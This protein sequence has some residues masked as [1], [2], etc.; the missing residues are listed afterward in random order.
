MN[1]PSLDKGT[2]TSFKKSI[3]ATF[4]EFASNWGEWFTDLLSPLQWLLINFEKLL[5]A[6]PWYVFLILVGFLI[7]KITYS[8]KL[9]L[10]FLI[11]FVSIGLVGMW[12]DTMR[13]LAIVIVSTLVCIVIGIPTGILMA[14]N[15]TAQRIILPIL[16][17]M[18]TIPSFVYLIPVVMLFGLGKVPGLI[19]IVVFAIPPVIR[20]TNLGLRQVDFNLVETA[21]AMGLKSKYILAF[22][23][24]PLARNVILG[25]VNQTVMMALAMVVI[26]SMIG[27]RGLGSQVMNS[28]GNGYLGLGVISGLSIVALAI[29]ID[30]TIQ[31]HN[32]RHDK[33]RNY[34]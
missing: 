22:I 18:Q 28:I 17:L 7:W 24:I 8:W 19:A 27:V 32:K 9:V 12:D 14:K 2:I 23:E 10:G 16:D 33:W 15:N 11:S 3:D 1:F 21:Q 5:L 31:A 29:I 13:T 4:R 30:R 6:T 25:G 26:A 20:F 34:K